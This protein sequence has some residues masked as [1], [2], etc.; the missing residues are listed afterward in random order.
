M[1]DYK[2]EE[3]LRNSIKDNKIKASH[4]EHIPQLKTCDN[5]SEAQFL[6]RVNHEF[7]YTTYNGGL[8][9]LSGRI[10]YINHKQI[11]AVTTFIRWDTTNIIKVIE[12]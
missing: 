9:K 5:W 3:I 6:G 11:Q 2:W 12:D 4:L 8:V 10:Y 1:A 7:K